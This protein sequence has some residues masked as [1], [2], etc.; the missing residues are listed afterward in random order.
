MVAG[1]GHG[2]SQGLEEEQRR[3]GIRMAAG[4]AARRRGEECQLPKS[5]DATR[6]RHAP[7]IRSSRSRWALRL[8]EMRLSGPVCT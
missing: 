2:W 5:H 8:H 4:Q 7:L 3:H 1:D 6:R